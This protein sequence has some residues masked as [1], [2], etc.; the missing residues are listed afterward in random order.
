MRRARTCAQTSPNRASRPRG[1]DGV[2]C[3][4]RPLPVERPREG[5]IRDAVVRN[6]RGERDQ[7]PR[8]MRTSRTTGE[9]RVRIAARWVVLSPACVARRRRKKKKISAPSLATSGSAVYTWRTGYGL[10]SSVT[11]NKQQ[12]LQQQL[13]QQQQRHRWTFSTAARP[14]HLAPAPL[15]RLPLVPRLWLHRSPAYAE[16]P[17]FPA[18]A[19]PSAPRAAR[20][21]PR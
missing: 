1:T 2:R 5:G 17:P 18:A 4:R 15:S 12:Q 21:P 20:S 3:A 19:H 8:I 10:Y 7:D 11:Y 14:S 16:E 6:T 13:Q 9:M